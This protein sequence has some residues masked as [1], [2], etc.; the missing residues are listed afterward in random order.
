[1]RRRPNPLSIRGKTFEDPWAA[2]L[3]RSAREANDYAISRGQSKRRR[4][5]AISW[6]FLLLGLCCVGITAYVMLDATAYQ[7]YEEYRFE[8]AREGRTGSPSAEAPAATGSR[9]EPAGKERVHIG[10]AELIGRIS[11]PRLR[12]SAIVREGDDDRTLRRAVGHVPGTALPGEA[13]NIGLAGHRDSFFRGL[14]NIQKNDVIRISTLEGDYNYVVDRIEIV[15]PKDVQVLN[16]TSQ[17][18]LT[19]ITCYPFHYVG[20]AP[21]R[22]VVQARGEVSRP[23]AP[24]GS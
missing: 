12:V 7:A 6:I 9:S 3:A 22:F 2:M 18:V 17:P 10:P 8:R 24:Q 13:G 1:M 5:A 15:G 19:L 23:R 16:T 14:K 20:N 4:W 21:R 11:I